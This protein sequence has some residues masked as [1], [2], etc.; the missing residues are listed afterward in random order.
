MKH[1]REAQTIIND[2]R[3]RAEDVAKTVKAEADE[4]AGRVRSQAQ[5]EAEATKEQS[6]ADMRDQII[7]LSMAAANH[8]IGES[9]DAKK[10]KEVVKGFF[11]DVPA[12]VKDL[13]GDVTVITAVPL[14]A[15][16]QKKFTSAMKGAEA[17]DFSVDPGILGGVVVRAGAQEVDSSFAAHLA[18]MRSSLN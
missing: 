10:Q 13:S 3:S 1:V 7:S 15:A 14:T 4:E 18:G 8:L 17:V 6:L 5:A 2:A 9:L 12:E 16:E 11:T